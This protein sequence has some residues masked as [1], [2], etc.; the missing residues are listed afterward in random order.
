MKAFNQYIKNKFAVCRLRKAWS[1]HVVLPRKAK[2]F[3]KNHNTHAQVFLINLLCGDVP[4]VGVVVVACLCF[5]IIRNIF[6]TVCK[7]YG[8]Y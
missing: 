6:P 2:I 8:K 4:V 1:F 3:S 5:V 7:F